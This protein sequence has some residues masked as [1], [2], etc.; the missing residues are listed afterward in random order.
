MLF[1]PLYEQPHT[2]VN[3]STKIEL[4]SKRNLE[5]FKNHKEKNLYTGMVTWTWFTI[6]PQFKLTWCRRPRVAPMAEPELA[7][8]HCCPSSVP[9][10]RRFHFGGNFKPNSSSRPCPHSLSSILDHS[11]AHTAGSASKLDNTPGNVISPLIEKNKR[12]EIHEH[13]GF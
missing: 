2:P 10:F 1:L 12:E 11:L 6:N 7:E 3:M 13:F 8:G 4:P 9:I 5:T